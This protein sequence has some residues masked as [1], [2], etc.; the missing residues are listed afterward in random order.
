MGNYDDYPTH[1]AQAMDL[2]DQHPELLARTTVP[3]V[4]PAIARR[5]RAI[6][7]RSVQLERERDELV[8]QAHEAGASLRE[9]AA[10]AG[11]SHVGI[12]KLLGRHLHPDGQRRL[13][14]EL[15]D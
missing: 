10:V 9:I 14:E 6:A 5:L 15:P 2:L 11:M 12:K 7:I 8:I 13:D 1:I 4:D 3:S